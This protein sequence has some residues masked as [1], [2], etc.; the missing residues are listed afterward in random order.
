MGAVIEAETLY[1]EVQDLQKRIRILEN[2]LSGV[3][4]SSAHIQSL[5]WDKAQGGTAVL[6]GPSNGNGILEVHDE[7]GLIK[8]VWDRDGIHIIDGNIIVENEDGE[9]TFDA[10]GIVSSTNFNLTNAARGS[11]NQ[12]ITSPSGT[13]ITGSSLSFTLER[14]AN[15]LILAAVAGYVVETSG[16]GNAYAYIEIDGVLGSFT[17]MLFGT[18]QNSLITSHAHYLA[19]NLP[20]GSHTIRLIG[21]L[22]TLSGSPDFIVYG[23]NFSYTKLGT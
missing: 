1:R 5:S 8:G 4:I 22:D 21:I 18:G 2:Y 20:T 12:S 19:I 16:E 10:K 14:S 13:L 15:I 6:G 7:A 11:A 17:R 3:P 9:V 23:Y